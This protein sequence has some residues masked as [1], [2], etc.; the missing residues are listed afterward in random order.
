M[1]EEQWRLRRGGRKRPET[2]PQP[3]VP[4]V[5]GTGGDD[6]IASIPAFQINMWARDGNLL[7]KLAV[8][9]ETR[10]E[11]IVNSPFLHQMTEFAIQNY[12]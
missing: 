11:A 7:K 2:P 4:P 12:I 10:M 5:G 6:A 1:L 9:P 3:P 8:Q